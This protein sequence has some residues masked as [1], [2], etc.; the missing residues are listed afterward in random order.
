MLKGRTKFF[1]ILLHLFALAGFAVLGA[2]AFYELGFTNNKGGVD[3]NNRYLADYKVENHLT[4]SSKIFENNMQDYLNLV[5]LSKFYPT[6]AHLIM[7]AAQN[8]DRTNGI[9]Q[10][11]YAANMYLQ[12]GDTARQYI[13]NWMPIVAA[14][15]SV[16]GNPEERELLLSWAN[17][18]DYQ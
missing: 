4:D 16:K 15:Q 9:G 5:A 14:S 11:L 12:E 18:F 3:D 6:N 10:M 1:Q 2:W 7:D 17:V 13:N 8:S